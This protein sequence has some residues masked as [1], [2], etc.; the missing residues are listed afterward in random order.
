MIAG[1]KG[2]ADW[3]CDPKRSVEERFG[4]ELLIELTAGLWNNKHGIKTETNYEAERL[5]KQ[6][7]ALDPGHEPHYSREAAEH[8]E[9]VLPE[10]K[11]LHFSYYDDRPLRSLAFLRFCPP[12][13]SIETRFSEISDWTPLLAQTELTKL[14]VWDRA[15]RDL[16]PLARLTKLK[17]LFL[18]LGAPWPDLAGLENLVELREFQFHGNIHV[19]KAVP[20]LAQVRVASI[21]HGSGYNLPLRQV[22][23]LPAMPELRRLLLENTAELGGIERYDKLL[24]LE[25]YGHFTD[26]SPLASLKNLTHL[27]LSGGDYPTIAPLAQMPQ[28]CRLVVRHEMPPD[29]TPLAESPRLHEIATESTHIVPPELASLNAMFNTWD[30]EFAAAEPR[31][32]T[33]LKLCLRDDHERGEIDSGGTKRDWGDDLE[34]DHSEYRW[35]IR[36]INRRITALLG[37]GWGEIQERFPGCGGGVH[38]TI[39]RPEDIDRVLEVVQC[40]RE[41]IAAAR[42]PWSYLLIVDSLARFERDMA[43]I[44]RNDDAEFDPDRERA[45]WEDERR[46]ERERREFLERKYRHRLQQELGSPGVPPKPAAAPA[47]ETNEDD[48][49]TLTTTA[50]A[51]E[52]EYDLGTNISLYATLTEKACYIHE[53]DR[54]IAEM[55][56]EIKAEE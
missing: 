11:Q 3:A 12:L 53:S 2:F 15:A 49:D 26:V 18:W 19:L 45:E 13:E 43:E 33:P 27:I 20:H 35:F 1:A 16:R 6:A 9:E 29:F 37:K 32:L 8:T 52:S 41:L 17:S 36:R 46:Q 56:L 7:R 23:D 47:D 5:R 10:L 4:A 44:Y 22:G 38:V 21:K 30:E 54:G 40:L 48:E 31:A 25:I 42:H 55:L 39:T 28:L 34:M 14:H 51:S 50:E 24:N